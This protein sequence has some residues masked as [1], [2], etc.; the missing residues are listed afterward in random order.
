MKLVKLGAFPMRPLAQFDVTF[1]KYPS[2]EWGGGS[3]VDPIHILKQDRFSPDQPL[4]TY[5]P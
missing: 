2:Q 4:D 3:Y 1:S 5:I